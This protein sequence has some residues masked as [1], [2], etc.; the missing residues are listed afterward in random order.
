VALAVWYG[1]PDH[2]LRRAEKIVE[3]HCDEFIAAWRHHFCA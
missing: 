2:E 1:I 3:E